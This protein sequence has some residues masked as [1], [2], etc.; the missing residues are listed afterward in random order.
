MLREKEQQVSV[1]HSVQ[2]AQV[3]PCCSCT[4]MIC[5][6][7]YWTA[8]IGYMVQSTEQQSHLVQQRAGW[9]CGLSGALVHLPHALCLQVPLQAAAMATA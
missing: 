6:E 5:H 2:H 7:P 4:Y 3:R 8:L 1:V 9:G